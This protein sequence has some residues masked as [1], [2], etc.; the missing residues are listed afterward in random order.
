M[1]INPDDYPQANIRRA[2]KIKNHND[3]MD[4]LYGEDD[5]DLNHPTAEYFPVTD[6]ELNILSN[7]EDNR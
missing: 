7:K 5:K 4:A 6:K 3:E 1:P 2:A